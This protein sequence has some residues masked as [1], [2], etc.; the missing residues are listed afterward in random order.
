MQNEAVDAALFDQRT[1]DAAERLFPQAAM[2]ACAG[3]PQVCMNHACERHQLFAITIA[4]D[5]FGPHRDAV[6]LKKD[7]DVREAVTDAFVAFSTD[8]SDTT[9]LALARKGNASAIARRASR[10][11]FQAASTFL[12]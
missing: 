9:S 7:G 6:V 4:G 11:S 1:R 3:N 12:P 10:V 5:E 8:G 2:T